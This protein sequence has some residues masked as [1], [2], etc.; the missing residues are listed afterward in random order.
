MQGDRPDRR[1]VR[2]TSE[3]D[4][5]ETEQMDVLEPTD[6]PEPHPANRRRLAIIAA[7]VVVALVGG[8]LAVWG[9]VSSSQ[10]TLSAAESSFLDRRELAV[11][12][13]ED[14]RDTVAEASEVHADSEG[15]VLDDAVR[16][17]LADGIGEVEDLLAAAESELASA[18]EVLENAR[19]GINVLA[20]GADARATATSLDDIRFSAAADLGEA[21]PGLEELM[22][23]VEAAVDEWEQR[24]VQSSYTKHVVATGWY[25]ELDR[26]EGAVDISAHYLDIPTIAEHWSCGGNSFPDEPGTV[27]T[28]TGQHAGLYRVEGIKA[29]LNIDIHDAGDIPT[30]YDLLYQTCQDGWSTSMSFTALTKIG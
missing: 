14:A 29:M 7:A 24:Q 21:L 15:R 22:A 20:L 18:D 23:A 10:Q 2:H 28:L 19:A 11:A 9:A 13:I 8:G 17:A 27:I 26:C 12:I 25:P 30:G 3:V 4:T 1:D 16:V 6:V 5:P